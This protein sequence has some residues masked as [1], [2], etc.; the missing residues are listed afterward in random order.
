MGIFKTDSLYCRLEKPL[1][2]PETDREIQNE[3]QRRVNDATSSL[4]ARISNATSEAREQV[5]RLF[6]A[7]CRGHT[8]SVSL[9]ELHLL[10]A[11]MYDF[12]PALNDGPPRELTSFKFLVEFAAVVSAHIGCIGREEFDRALREDPSCLVETLIDKTGWFGIDQEAGV[13]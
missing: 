8:A 7:A 5:F 9:K 3:V 11:R 13:A 1:F 2:D 10:H 12:V 4:H 6:F